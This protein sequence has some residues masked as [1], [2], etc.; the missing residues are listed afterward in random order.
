M[1]RALVILIVTL[2]LVVTAHAQP[3]TREDA[4]AMVK[5][6]QQSFRMQGAQTT[7]KAVSDPSTK[8]FHDGDLYPF[9]YDQSGILVANGGRSVLIGKK[10][11]DVKDP[12]GKFPI[13]EMIDIANGPGSGWVNYKWIN[14]QTKKLQK[15][16]TYIERMGEYLVGAGVYSD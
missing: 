2:L 5:R 11:I 9:I 6:V 16:S 8:E 10:M 13:R 4:V 12:D 3:A 1:K 7:F 15:K 14:L